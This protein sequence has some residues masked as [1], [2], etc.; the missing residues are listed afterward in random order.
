MKTLRR[1]VSGRAFP[2]KIQLAGILHSVRLRLSLWFGLVLAVILVL[3][4]AFVYYRQAQD[5]RDS[6]LSR[7]LGR[8]RALYSSLIAAGREYGG[9][10]WQPYGSVSPF[11]LEDQEVLLLSDPQGKLSGLWSGAAGSSGDEAN[12]SGEG[13][14]ESQE[15]A[16][17]PLIDEAQAAQVASQVKT[18]PVDREK[19]RAITVTLEVSSERGTRRSDYLFLPTPLVADNALLG[20]M[21]LGQ[22]TDPYGQLPRLA[23]TLA[24]GTALTLLVALAG[25]FW[26][27]DRA[28][29]PVKAI[30][31]TAQEISESD[32]SR[33]LNITTRDELGALAGTFDRMLD[34]LQAA[35]NRQRQFTADAS[36]ELRTPLTIIGL[37][38]GRALGSARSADEFRRALRVIE[39]ENEYMSRLVNELLTLARMDAGQVTLKREPLDLSDLALEVVER[40]APLAAQK[41][42]RL[43]T[44]PLP[45]LPIHGDRQYLGQ[46]IG[47][48]VDNAIKYHPAGAASGT[49]TASATAWVQV[50]TCRGAGGAACLRVID[51]G[52][53]IPNE[54]LPLLFERF[55]RV[56]AARSHNPDESGEQAVHGSGL[57]LSIVQWIA[58]MHGGSVTVESEAGQGTTFEIRLPGA[59]DR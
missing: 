13:E 23:F 58:K 27:A 43:L 10:G 45:E 4:S 12:G 28:L 8:Q 56:D 55:Y 49:V 30:T 57:G 46:M 22:P 38:T 2:G 1:K 6:A 20:W 17:K 51:N 36:H 44:G 39:S 32:L 42:V 26:L 19:L 52:P 18:L 59:A 5:V 33:R 25:G 34:R 50:E 29:W 11:T 21:I 54:H 35:F 14:P 41:G 31:R 48:L 7:L 24:L 37:E 15:T 3:F 9:S 16:S 53:G 47:N 40:Y